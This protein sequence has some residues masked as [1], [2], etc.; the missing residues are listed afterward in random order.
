MFLFKN[1]KVCVSLLTV[2]LVL[3]SCS[4]AVFPEIIEDD[5][6]GLSSKSQESSALIADEENIAYEN[7]K[8]ASYDKITAAKVKPVFKGKNVDLG[9]DD[10]IAELDDDDFDDLMSDDV[11]I[12]SAPK[13]DFAETV[14]EAAPEVVNNTEPSVTYRLETFYFDNGSSNLDASS[15]SKIRN[16]VKTAKANKAKV[17]VVGF[18]SSRTRNTDATS[19]KLANFKV[20]AD[21]A[22][23]VAKA[24][25]RAGLSANQ[26]Q[27]E[28][29]SDTSPV[30]VEV[31]PEGERL[32]RRAEVYISY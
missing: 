3:S 24:L 20:S 15:N 8:D 30:Y 4:S 29:L 22:E 13:I 31:M 14:T 23:A 19:H 25:K 18:A 7:G 28:A 11:K 26:I 27:V 17:N 12:P 21:R 1:I 32:N 2:T 9:M 6:A 16:I 10:E 5:Q